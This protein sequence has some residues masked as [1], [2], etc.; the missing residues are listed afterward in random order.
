MIT[1]LLV[2]PVKAYQRY[3][4]LYFRQHVVTDQRVQLI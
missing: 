1:T 2:A 3:I 4:S